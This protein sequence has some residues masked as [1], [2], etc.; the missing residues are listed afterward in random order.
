MLAR[1][2]LLLLALASAGCSSASDEPSDAGPQGDAAPRAI[3]A[4]GAG[5][6]DAMGA[7]ED[8]NALLEALRSDRDA[9]MLSQSRASGWPAA[10]ADGYLFVSTEGLPLVAGDHDSWVGTAMTA[11]DDFY[12]VV[13]NVPPGSR[14]KFTDG[15]V[16]FR[17][18]P[19]SRAYA[20]DDQGLMSMRPPST[21]HLER[22]FAVGDATGGI[23]DR[24]LRVWLPQEAATHI[25][26]THDGQNL[27]DPNALFG[28]WKLHSVA[29]A[30]LMIVGIDNVG[31]DRF[32]EYS[33]S[34]DNGITAKGDAYAAYVQET[35]RDL[36]ALH[37]GEPAKVGTMGSSMG[38][39]IALHLVDRYPGEYDF[40]ASLSGTLGWGSIE[41]QGTDTI[42]ARYMAAGHRDTAI[43]IDSG[44]NGTTCVDSD[45]DGTND[46][47]SSA[48]DN[49]CETKQME[50]TLVGLG[51]VYDTDLWHW[52]EPNAG[53][54]EIAWAA[55]VFR[56]LADFMSL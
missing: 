18:D 15:D 17:P 49:Y 38:G 32:A 14:Y 52:H 30:G 27:F 31:S 55:R 24:T 50:T 46:D 22:F 23:P 35:V 26:Y 51:Y 25:L 8:L 37:Y 2:A 11:E 53:H 4:M 48:T 19:W 20:Y 47:D 12:W 39:L 29:P 33:H 54:N 6:A 1:L 13:L 16:D 21:S 40:A 34:D 41:G 5:A 43:Y 56:P 10:V 44:G 45:A 9:A 36:I 3:D 7:H 42:I 28:G